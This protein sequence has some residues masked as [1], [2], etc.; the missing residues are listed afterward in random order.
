MNK[1]L[2]LAFFLLV[3]GMPLSSQN[4]NYA[5]NTLNIPMIRKRGDLVLGVGWGH[6]TS[7]LEVQ[8]VYSPFK[9]VMIAAN[10][11]G[12]RKG[13]VRR[14]QKEGTDYYLGELGIGVYESN[15][16]TTIS[17][18]AGLGA[19][20]IFSNYSLNNSAELNLQR[21]FVQPGIAYRSEF[22]QAA[23][24]LRF[25]RLNYSQGNISFS[26]NP[27]D[28]AYIRNIEAKNPIVVP[29]LGVQAGIIYE[30]MYL[31]LAISSIVLNTSLWD[32]SR[33]NAA[34]VL[35]TT[36]HIRRKGD[37]KAQGR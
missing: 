13:D 35:N 17:L 11:F 10:Y 28:L 14:Q 33:L 6:A 9:R 15:K 22:F 12:A 18:M 2:G 32:F 24:G 21:W 27:N 3:G 5:P 31:G 8:S 37:T 30:R 20:R 19:G 26:I 7:S 29:E 25:S 16:H 36:F 4:F 23:A 34:L 1:A